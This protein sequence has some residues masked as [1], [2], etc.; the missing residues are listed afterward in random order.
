MMAKE[1]GFPYIAYHIITSSAEEAFC[2]SG[3][4]KESVYKID[5]EWKRQ[6]HTKNYKVARLR[7]VLQGI[8]G[9][10]Q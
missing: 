2:E 5:A 7:N 1:L 9:S 3:F 8:Q 10:L 6:M 4:D